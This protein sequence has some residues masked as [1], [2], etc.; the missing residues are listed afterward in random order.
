MFLLIPCLGTESLTLTA[1]S[2]E[3]YSDSWDSVPQDATERMLTDADLAPAE[4]ATP[5]TPVATDAETPAPAP[6]ANPESSAQE[7]KESVPSDRYDLPLGIIGEVEPVFVEDIPQPFTARIDTG[8]SLCS[9]DADEVKFFERD[10]KPWVSFCL[11]HR[12]TGERHTFERK[13][14]RQAAIK[15]IGG[16]DAQKRPLVE[17]TVRI[18]EMTL[19][20]DFTLSDRGNFK[21]QVLIGRNLLN[22]VA[23]VDVSRSSSLGL[24]QLEQ[25]ERDG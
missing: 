8:A 10:G 4:P 24:E 18:G 9:L 11:V 15:Q 5:Q 2:A 13:V 21:F 17:M 19:Q 14:K 25:V 23:A 16:E 22:G 3:S 12:E 6:Q 1:Y 20:R 7:E